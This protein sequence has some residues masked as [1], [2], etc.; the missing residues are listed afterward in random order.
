MRCG[1]PLIAPAGDALRPTSD[2]VREAL[3][4]IL[5]A[6]SLGGPELVGGHFLDAFAGTGAAAI[7]ALSRGARQATLID[8]DL[9]PARANI[10]ALGLEK[11]TILVGAD[12]AKLGPAPAGGTAD[13]AFLD[14]PYRSGLA[15]PALAALQRG[16]WLV[17]G[18]LVIVE[19]A[20]RDASEL[21]GESGF[22]LLEERR[23]G[24][25]RLSFLRA[26]GI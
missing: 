7:E 25:A 8:R 11:E 10:A 18:A 22:E 23:Y 3:F 26:P 6:G 15:V 20:S 14:P 19:T 24:A 16:G 12:V 21:P 1:R 9:K 4:N 13:V 5:A 17:R 2:R